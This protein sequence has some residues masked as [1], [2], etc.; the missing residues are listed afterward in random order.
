MAVTLD[1]LGTQSLRWGND[2]LLVCLLALGQGG[3][4]QGYHACFGTMT[5]NI[6]HLCVKCC[7]P[8]DPG[9]IPPRGRV[10]YLQSLAQDG[11][12]HRRP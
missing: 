4:H 12:N 8:E 9:V 11:T 3:H 6:Q 7:H 10:C 2:C 1:G 5:R